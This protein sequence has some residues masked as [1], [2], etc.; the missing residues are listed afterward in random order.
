M[1]LSKQIDND[2]K[3][4]ERYFHEMLHL[5]KECQEEEALAAMEVHD[6]CAD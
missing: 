2:C 6:T 5:L 4:I 1:K 3:C